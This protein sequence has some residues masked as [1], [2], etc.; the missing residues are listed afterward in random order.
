VGDYVV[1]KNNRGQFVVLRKM[2]VP[3][4]NISNEWIRVV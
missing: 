3:I 1:V 2:D 4:T